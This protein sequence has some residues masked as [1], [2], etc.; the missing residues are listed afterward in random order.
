MLLTE[1]V[2]DNFG[3][4]VTILTIF[5]TNIVHLLDSGNKIQK[6][7]SISKFRHPLVT[8]IYVADFFNLLR[9]FLDLREFPNLILEHFKVVVRGKFR[10]CDSCVATD[11][12]QYI[13]TRDPLTDRKTEQDTRQYVYPRVRQHMFIICPGLVVPIRYLF[14]FME[15][16]AF[17]EYLYFNIPMNI[18]SRDTK[19]WKGSRKFWNISENSMGHMNVGDGCWRPNC[20][21]D[22]FEILVTDLIH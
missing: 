3:M 9:R 19:F 8:N 10:L 18:F 22:K 20:V 14:V 21:G 4:L 13:L 2:G 12:S 6:M 7:S 11:I 1:C 15:Q 16:K 17:L 5:V